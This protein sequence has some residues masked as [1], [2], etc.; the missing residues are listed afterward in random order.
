MPQDPMTPTETESSTILPETQE[1]VLALHAEEI[2]IAKRTIPHATV[3]VSKVTRIHDQTVRETL[4][5]ERIEVERIPVGTYID[6]AP[7]VR[8]DGDVTVLSVIEEV[9][10]TERRLLLK[11]EVRIRRI[12]TTEDHVETVALRVEEALVERIPAQHSDA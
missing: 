9:L 10:V 12:Q 3:L 1:R 4:T 7:P 6:V 11:E 2:A 5:R 8:Q